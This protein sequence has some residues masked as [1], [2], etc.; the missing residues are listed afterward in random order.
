MFVIPQQALPLFLMPSLFSSFWR[1]V[2]CSGHNGNIVNA[3]KLREELESSGSIFQSTMDSEVIIHLMARNLKHGLE[4]A[5][6]AALSRVEGAYSFIM[7]TRDKIIAAR[8][9]GV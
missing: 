7:L 9:P 2:L 6:V 8:D 5:L 1:R 3:Q 4:E